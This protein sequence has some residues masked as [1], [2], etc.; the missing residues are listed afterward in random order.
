MY[1]YIYIC[2][3][4]YIY[5]WMEWRGLRGNFN[6]PKVCILYLQISVDFSGNPWQYSE[7]QKIQRESLARI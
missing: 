7:F 1:M 3:Y 2:T 5:S 4:L 6:T